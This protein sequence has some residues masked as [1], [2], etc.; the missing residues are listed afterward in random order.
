MNIRT[1]LL[2]WIATLK[3][4]RLNRRRIRLIQVVLCVCALIVSLILMYIYAWRALN[5]DIGL[6]PGISAQD[7]ALNIKTL[8]EFNQDRVERVRTQSPSFGAAVSFFE[9]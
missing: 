2:V 4:I 7:P 6:P 5:Q 1:T 9:Q 8:Q 3:Q